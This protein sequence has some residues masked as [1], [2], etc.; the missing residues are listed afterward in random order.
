M[1]AGTPFALWNGPTIVAWLELWV[2]MPAWSVCFMAPIM[3]SYLNDPCNKEKATEAAFYAG[4]FAYS[5]IPV[6]VRGGVSR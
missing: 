4:V 5:L 3:Q 2:G 1:K 6:Q